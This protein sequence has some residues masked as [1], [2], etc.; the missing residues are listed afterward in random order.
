MGGRR[1]GLI[2]RRPLSRGVHQFTARTLVAALLAASVSC[3]AQAGKAELFG[4][5]RDSQGR[6]VTN[7]KVT[8]NESATG[9]R[10]DVLS[11]DR[12]DY[13]LLGV[14]AGQYLLT[15]DRK[16][17]LLNSSH[18]NISYAVFCLKKKKTT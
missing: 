14:P 5:I 17:T 9:A 8:C 4:T 12:G 18:A 1:V 3:F 10:F 15:V 13:H 11:D 7:A 16:S 2:R 6:V